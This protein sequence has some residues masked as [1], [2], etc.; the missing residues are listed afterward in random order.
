MKKIVSITIFFCFCVHSNT[1]TQRLSPRLTSAFPAPDS[2]TLARPVIRNYDPKEYGAAFNYWAIA[3]DQRGV[4]YL[5]I[6]RHSRIRR[7]FVCLIST[8]NKS[9][10]RSLAIDANFAHGSFSGCIY[11]GAVG[12]L[13]YSRRI[14]L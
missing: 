12:D 9:G 4:M 5:A 7:R 1:Y 13:G 3:Q 11:V 10:V 6:E 2:P 8:P 14:P